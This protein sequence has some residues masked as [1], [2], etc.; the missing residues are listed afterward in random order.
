MSTCALQRPKR[1]SAFH[2]RPPMSRRIDLAGP[3]RVALP[4]KGPTCSADKWPSSALRAPRRQADWHC[5]ADPPHWQ[6]LNPHSRLG[7]DNHRGVRRGLLPRGLWDTCPH[8]VAT[9]HER[10][11]ATTPA[12]QP[13][14][15]DG[16]AAEE[17]G[18]GAHPLPRPRAGAAGRAG[19]NGSHRVRDDHC[20]LVATEVTAYPHPGRH[21]RTAASETSRCADDEGV[22]VQGFRVRELVRPVCAGEDTGASGRAAVPGTAPGAQVSGSHGEARRTRLA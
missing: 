19:R 13:A 9:R 21:V 20:A 2:R 16:Q 12:T 18:H 7:S 10:Q 22:G 15:R 1:S 8:V 6:A 17:R 4:P 14:G 5:H 11:V 3:Q